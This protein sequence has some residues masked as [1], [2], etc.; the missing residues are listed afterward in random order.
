MVPCL[1]C[2]CICQQHCEI[3]SPFHL[4]LLS[5]LLFLLPFLSSPPSVSPPPCL[6]QITELNEDVQRVRT[7][8]QRYRRGGVRGGRKEVGRGDREKKKSHFQ[9]NHY[10][11]PSSPLPPPFSLLPPP[12]SPVFLLLPLSSSLLLPL[13]LPLSSFLL[14]PS[15]AGQ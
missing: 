14:P 6:T 15:Q 9:L 13:S 5:M 12:P 10:G 4:L 11:P 2:T 1:L 8:Q 7:E 3:I